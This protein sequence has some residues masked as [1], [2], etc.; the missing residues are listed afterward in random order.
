MYAAR[1]RILRARR[2]CLSRGHLRQEPRQALPGPPRAACSRPR[3][4]CGELVSSPPFRLNCEPGAA[5]EMNCLTRWVGEDL[6]RVQDPGRV[7]CVLH[8][9][10]GIEVVRAV[11]PGHERALFEPDAVLTRQRSA[12]LDDGAQHLLARGLDLVKDLAVPHVEEDVRME[13]AV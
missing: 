2:P 4:R 11:D 5:G 8:A 9:M 3:R 10:H 1:R 12:E 7:E 6:S 13:V